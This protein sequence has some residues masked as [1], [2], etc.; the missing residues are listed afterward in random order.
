MTNLEQT[1]K[2]FDG[3][4]Q[5]HGDAAGEKG[6]YKDPWERQYFRHGIVKGSDQHLRYDLGDDADRTLDEEPAVVHEAELD[7]ATLED[8]FSLN[9][10]FWTSEDNL[11]HGEV[12]ETEEA[13]EDDEAGASY[14]YTTPESE[15]GIK[16]RR[17]IKASLA[18]KATAEDYSEDDY[19]DDDGEP[20]MRIHRQ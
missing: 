14:H 13:D 4:K 16:D 18:R 11:E 17:K 19:G 15:I 6:H 10:P 1:H 2:Q 7:D 5:D 8:I 12:D 3:R 20:S 9:D